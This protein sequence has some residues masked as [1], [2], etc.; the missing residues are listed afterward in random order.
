MPIKDCSES[1]NPF[2]VE[3]DVL[4]GTALDL[5]LHFPHRRLHIDDALLGDAD[6]NIQGEESVSDAH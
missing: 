5:L 1:A 2:N 4:L 6:G 3:L